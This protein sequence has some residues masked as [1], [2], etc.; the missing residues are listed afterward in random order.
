MY[1]VYVR[2]FIVFRKFTLKYLGIKRHNMWNLLSSGSEINNI[3]IEKE[4]GE[5]MIKQ[6]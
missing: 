4:T 2:D 6:M 3:Y 5:R 1:L